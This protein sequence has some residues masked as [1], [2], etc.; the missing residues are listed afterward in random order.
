[1]MK[2]L[3]IGI[4]VIIS[5]LYLK[6]E[7]FNPYRWDGILVMKHN[8]MYQ[9]NPELSIKYSNGDIKREKAIGIVKGESILEYIFI[10]WVIKL[11]GF[12]EEETF[13]IKGLMFDEVYTKV[14]F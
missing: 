3:L 10:T 13:L 11:E 12:D 4:L 8:V 9:G 2:K 7:V 1:M 6:F 5:V 14:D